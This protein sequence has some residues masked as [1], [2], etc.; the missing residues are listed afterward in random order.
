M[1][2]VEIFGRGGSPRGPPASGPARWDRNAMTTVVTSFASTTG[3]RKPLPVPQ[4][5][6]R[7]DR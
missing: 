4:L 3:R 7:S 2:I 6:C 1:M 5:R